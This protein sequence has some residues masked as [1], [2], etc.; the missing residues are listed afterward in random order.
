MSAAAASGGERVAEPGGSEPGAAGA[1]ARPGS[2]AGVHGAAR[3]VTGGG[4]QWER[5]GCCARR[6][7]S[8]GPLPRKG[9]RAVNG[10]R[11]S[12]VPLGY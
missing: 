1:A 2:R 11:R 9:R 8:V 7:R 6:G 10:S 4:R 3:H 5:Q 12:A